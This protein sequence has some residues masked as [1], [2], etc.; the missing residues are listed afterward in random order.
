MNDLEHL[1]L[2]LVQI[3]EY[4]IANQ[5]NDIGVMASYTQIEA[6][7]LAEA[8]L[9]LTERITHK[10][11][12]EDDVIGELADVMQS[13]FVQACVATGIDP[14]NMIGKMQST[15]KNK[16]TKWMC[17]IQEAQD[18]VNWKRLA[19][20]ARLRDCKLVLVEE[21]DDVWNGYG[22]DDL[23]N[24]S[25]YEDRTIYLGVYD[26]VGDKVIAFF[27]KLAAIWFGGDLI[28]HSHLEQKSMLIRKAKE[29]MNTYGIKVRPE[30][31]DIGFSSDHYTVHEDRGN[32]D[33]QITAVARKNVG[34]SEV[35]SSKDI[36]PIATRYPES[37]SLST[38]HDVE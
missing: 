14:I 3:A 29:L 36:D 19:N 7:E 28:G 23:F 4:V 24:V 21:G 6:S 32:C 31:C 22:Q 1:S 26:L 37:Q 16:N 9:A 12:T 15:L 35:L 11:A 5:A 25:F 38:E 34:T 10:Q 13:A 27:I 17:Q 8:S 2:D 20:I 18:E 33:K 30:E